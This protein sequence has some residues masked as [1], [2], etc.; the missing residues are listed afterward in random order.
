[1]T[2]RLYEIT[3]HYKFLLNELYDEETGEVNDL[4]LDKLN[5]VTDSLETKCINVTRVFKAIDAERSAIE[6][7]R[8]SMQAREKA[9]ENQVDR[10]KQY[11]LSNMELC[12][13]SEIKCP[14]FVIKVQKNPPK[15]DIYDEAL[16]DDEYKKIKVDFDV[17]KIKAGLQNGGVIPGARLIQG[18]SLRIR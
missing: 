9:L 5:E 7:E 8:K 18:N 13:I 10:L 4:V 15:V 1:M 2:M 3:D 16:I 6:R 17:S 14:Q 11:L 12:E